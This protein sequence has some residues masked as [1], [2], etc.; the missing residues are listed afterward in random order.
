MRRQI[1][2]LGRSLTTKNGQER[3]ITDRD[4]QRHLQ[5]FMNGQ[6][7]HSDKCKAFTNK[8]CMVKVWRSSME[9]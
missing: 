4:N 3:I 6:W 5:F 8:E 9:T 2:V 7:R 1:E